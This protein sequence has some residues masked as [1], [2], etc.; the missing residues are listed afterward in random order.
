MPTILSQSVQDLLGEWNIPELGLFDLDYSSPRGFVD[1]VK[2]G[3]EAAH[4]KDWREWGKN[5][6]I[7]QRVE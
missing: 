3:I 6:K 4:G 2:Q 1:S 7:L 5:V